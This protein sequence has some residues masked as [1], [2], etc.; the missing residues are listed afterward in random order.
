MGAAVPA[1]P[2]EQSCLPQNTQN[3]QNFSQGVQQSLLHQ[4]SNRIFPRNSQ[5]SQIFLAE[6]ILPRISQILT[7]F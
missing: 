6:N 7:D 3:S 5:I 1:A 2:T 4:P